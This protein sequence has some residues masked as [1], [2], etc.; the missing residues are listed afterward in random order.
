MCSSSKLSEVEP[1]ELLAKG[2]EPFCLPPLVRVAWAD[3]NSGIRKNH[4]TEMYTTVEKCTPLYRNELH[5][6]E[7]YATAQWFTE[8][9]TIVQK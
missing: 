4:C 6:T 2:E 7:M 8:M 9:Y 5:C 1:L 3:Q